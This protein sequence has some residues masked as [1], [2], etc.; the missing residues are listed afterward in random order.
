MRKTTAAGGFLLLSLAVARV[1]AQTD[2]RQE[3]T[4]SPWVKLLVPVLEGPG[5]EI[6]ATARNRQ[7]DEVRAQRLRRGGVV[8]ESVAPD[9]PASR[10]GLRKG[11]VIIELDYVSVSEA[12]QFAWLVHD[13]PPGRV[14]P[15]VVVRNGVRITLA[16]IPQTARA[17]SSQRP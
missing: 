9:S 5:S 15:T 3:T 11:D 17:G 16:L 8:V 7:S 10:A 13:T 4:P 14:L 1:D 12:R 6:G 2:G